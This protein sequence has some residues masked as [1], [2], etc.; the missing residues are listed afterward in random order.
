MSKQVEPAFHLNS[1]TCPHCNA[2]AQ[3]EWLELYCRQLGHTGQ[4]QLMALQPTILGMMVSV[5]P[6]QRSPNE[7]IVRGLPGFDPGLGSRAAVAMLFNVYGSKCYACRQIAIWIGDSCYY[8]APRDIAIE[9]NADLDEDTREDFREA[10]SIVNASPRGAAALLRLCIQKLLKQ[11]GESGKDINQDI[12]NLVQNKGLN[13]SI[14]RALDIVRVIGNESVHPGEL[15]M[16]DDRAT[17]MNLFGLVNLI[18]DA[19]I[20][21]PRQ[22][23]TMFGN[24][25]PNKLQGIENRDKKKP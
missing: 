25:P 13:A 18:A 24:L 9:P 20:S 4:E 22:I 15:N 12:A 1:F 17:A 7:P 14:Q 16:K 2:H 6:G 19:M 5:K 21:Q 11:I 3:Q 23:D 8:P 10:A